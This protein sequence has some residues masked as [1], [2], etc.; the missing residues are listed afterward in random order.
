MVKQEAKPQF[1]NAQNFPVT[2]HG[3]DRKQ[4]V[5]APYREKGRKPN[6]IY[7]VEGEY[8][9][10]FVSAKGP[11]A[12]LPEEEAV[13]APPPPVA[14]DKGAAA[15]TED[16]GD[17]PAPASGPDAAATKEAPKAEVKPKEGSLKDKAKK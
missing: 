15:P 11:L 13:A 7:V 12:P 17:K 4:F 16:A 1:I 6:A 5:V 14:A 9:R 10:Q 3:E 8:Y 2:I